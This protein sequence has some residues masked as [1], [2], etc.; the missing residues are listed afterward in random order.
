MR[1]ARNRKICYDEN[2]LRH[3]RADQVV[4]F[5]THIWCARIGAREDYDYRVQIRL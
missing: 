3:R 1:N 5:E 2:K 4:R